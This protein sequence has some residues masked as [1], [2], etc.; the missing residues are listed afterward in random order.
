MEKLGFKL[1]HLQLISNDDF[2]YLDLMKDVLG[3]DISKWYSKF[4]LKTNLEKMNKMIERLKNLDPK[5]VE[6]NPDCKILKPNDIGQIPFVA[7]MEIQMLLNS[8]LKAE[9]LMADLITMSCFS[10]NCKNDFIK[11]G[12]DYNRLKNRVLNSDVEDMVALFNW[13]L[14][15]VDVTNKMWTEL[16]FKVEVD[17]P[18]WRAAGGERLSQ[19][20]VIQTIRIICKE[21]N[22]SYEQ[23]WQIPYAVVQTLNLA[24]ATANFVQTEMTKI[25]ESRM[26]QQRSL[27]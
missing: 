18:D 22:V 14:E 2:N 20:N 16:F 5:D 10:S 11:D 6:L 4:F 1:K 9:E 7:M 15:A 24:T 21:L 26:R 8:D 17:D 19:F 27:K 25:K 3:Y 12:G 13:A 23:A